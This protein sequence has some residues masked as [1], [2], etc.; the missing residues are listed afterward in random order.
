MDE[1]AILAG[2]RRGGYSRSFTQVAGLGDIDHNC[3]W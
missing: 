1:A 2:L 3:A